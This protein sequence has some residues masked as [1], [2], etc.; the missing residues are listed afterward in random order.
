MFIKHVCARD[1]M[2]YLCT[3]ILSYLPDIVCS[4]SVFMTILNVRGPGYPGLTSSIS[5]L[6]M[7]WCPCFTRSSAAMILTIKICPC[8][9]LGRTSFNCVM[10]LWRKDIHFEYV[11]M[12]PLKNISMQRV[13]L[14]KSHCLTSSANYARQSQVYRVSFQYKDVLRVKGSPF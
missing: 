11:L 9:R 6:L 1:D 2:A 13:A 10:L 5:R 3:I 14:S 7:P 8:L 12:L 4:P